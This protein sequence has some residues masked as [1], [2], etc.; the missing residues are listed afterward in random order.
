MKYVA[1]KLFR[2]P[3]SL[4]TALPALSEPL[5]SRSIS[6]LARRAPVTVLSADRTSSTTTC[7]SAVTAMSVEVE[8]LGGVERLLL[9]LLRLPHHRPRLPEHEGAG[10][11]LCERGGALGG[12]E[13][14]EGAE[15]GVLARLGPGDQP[16]PHRLHHPRAHPCR[17]SERAGAGVLHQAPLDGRLLPYGLLHVHPCGDVD[18]GAEGVEDGEAGVRGSGGRIPGFAVVHAGR[19][20]GVEVRPQRQRAR[21]HPDARCCPG[22]ATALPR[23]RPPH[24][25]PRGSGGFEVVHGEE[26]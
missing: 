3:S 19:R 9:R 18:F 25:G 1:T 12:G 17:R 22:G 2:W 8:A 24:D 6:P 16:L 13:L 21:H 23:P 4:L 15:E 14:G 5:S 26:V 10:E 20:E 7:P 11:R